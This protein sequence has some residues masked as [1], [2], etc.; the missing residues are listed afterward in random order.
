DDDGAGKMIMAGLVVRELKLRGLVERVFVLF[1]GNPP[2]P[3]QPELKEKFEEKFI[4]LKGGD[5]REQF[6]INQWLENC[7]IITSLD[8]A[9]RDTILPGLR[10]VQWDLV[11]SMRLTGC[12]GLH[13]HGRQGA[14]R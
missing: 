6:G 2:F 11:L 4:V 8:L 13:P 7:Q 14:T 12:R 10:Q 1:S 3:W 9:K 5:I